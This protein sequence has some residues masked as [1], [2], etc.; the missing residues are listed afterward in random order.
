MYS[1]TDIK[2]IEY[3]CKKYDFKFKHGLGQNFL[4]AED[5]LFAIADAAEIDGGGVLEIGP[6]FGCLTAVLD[7]RA[8]KTV[9]L[10]V[11]KKLAPVLSETL[12]GYDNI[13]IIYEDV[14]KCNLNELI[15]D[16]FGDEKVSVAA[17]LPYYITTPVIMRLLEEKLPLKNI[18]IMVQKEVA[19]RICSSPGGKEY[20]AVTISVNYYAE[21]AMI[22][23]VSRDLFVP[24]P[25]VDSA[26]LKLSVREKPPV[27]VND[28]K[29]FFALVKAAF[30]Q[31]RKTLLN[32]L[33]NSGMFGDAG[34]IS[35]AIS[36][37][38]FDPKIRGERLSIE[39]FAKLSELL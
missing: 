6:G 21:P 33:K 24:A 25:N 19:E 12:A 14:L 5:V 13:K 4:T 23:D 1:L 35:A 26:V 32:A 31:R 9:S 16:N 8:K 15:K 28:E 3:L 34:K 10:E 38:G 7:A 29:R 39:D 20:G 11:D 18:V 36:A 30:A 2:T 37:M 22:C 27:C 17:N